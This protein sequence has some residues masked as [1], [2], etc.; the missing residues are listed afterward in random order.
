MAE[1]MIS[2]ICTQEQFQSKPFLDCIA[3]L[4]GNPKQMH[5]KLWEWCFITQALYERGLLRPGVSGLGF[6]V[7]TE[8][9]VS[10][11]CGEGASVCATDLFPDAAKDQGWLDTNAHASSFEGLNGAKFC[12][13]ELFPER[14]SLRYV[15]MNHVPDDLRGFDFLWSSCAL[16]H[17]GSLE[18]GEAFI[19]D[20]MKCLKPGGI[21]VHTT[22]YNVSSNEETVEEGITVLYRRRD[23]EGIAHNLREMGHRI[24]VDFS[25]GTLPADKFVDVP[26]YKEDPHLKLRLKEYT[27]T[28]IG[29]IVEKSPDDAGFSLRRFIG[30][31]LGK[32]R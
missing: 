30:K 11:F 16:E 10:Y 17:L 31:I 6:G 3:R 32:N 2:K 22:E 12:P 7:G 18:R 23:I 21:A 20:A 25:L 1:L 5:R 28:S 26:P 27:I 9:L 24:E 8:P 4:R 19:Y 13:D 15:D 14:C 29:L